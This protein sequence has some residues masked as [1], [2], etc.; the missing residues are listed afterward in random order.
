[1]RGQSER[2]ALAAP[3][4]ATKW[5]VAAAATTANVAGA[6]LFQL[7]GASVCLRGPEVHVDGV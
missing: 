6:V 5:L 4:W 7:A 2:S 1:M 3:S